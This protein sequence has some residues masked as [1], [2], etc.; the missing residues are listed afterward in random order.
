L[1]AVTKH[2]SITYDSVLGSRINAPAKRARRHLWFEFEKTTSC[3]T[4]ADIGF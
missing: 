2:P 3:I 1:R 4:L